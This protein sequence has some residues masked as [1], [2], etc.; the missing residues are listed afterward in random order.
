MKIMYV[1]DDHDD[2]QMIMTMRIMIKILI[3]EL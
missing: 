2:N 1:N 3:T